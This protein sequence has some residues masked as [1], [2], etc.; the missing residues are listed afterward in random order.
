V[1]LWAPVATRVV[2]FP[3][4]IEV[5]FDA[6]TI[7]G[8]FD[9]KTTWYPEL[10]HDPLEPK[11]WY[12]VETNGDTTIT[13]PVANPGTHEYELAPVA[14]SVIVVPTHIFELLALAVTV[15]LGNTVSINVAFDAQLFVIP[16]TVYTDVAVGVTATEGANVPIGL[17][18]YEAAPLA[19]RVTVLPEHKVEGNGARTSVGYWLT[20]TWT[21]EEVAHPLLLVPVT[22]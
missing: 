20:V 5:G 12:K 22:V 2:V 19:A 9:T 3:A 11:T 4:H 18:V 1:K 17:H 7:L 14:V 6:A 15:G 13:D 21:V 10:V 8:G 16:T